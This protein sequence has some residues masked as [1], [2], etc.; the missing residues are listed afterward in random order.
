[1][2]YAS[3]Q[4]QDFVKAVAAE[5]SITHTP[6]ANAR[7]GTAAI[8]SNVRCLSLWGATPRII[9]MVKVVFD[10]HYPTLKIATDDQF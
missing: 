3:K 2:E 8:A 4:L 5:A 7:W 6:A 10:H 9:S 1:M